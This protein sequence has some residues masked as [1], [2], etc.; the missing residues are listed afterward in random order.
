[1]SYKQFSSF[2]PYQGTVDA[3]PAPTKPPNAFDQI[4][5]FLCRKGR[6][7][8][9]PGIQA[10]GNPLDG[11]ILRN[12]LTFEDAVGDFHSLAL[13]T[14]TPYFVTSGPTYNPLTLPGGIESLAGTA[15]PFGMSAINNRIYFSNGSTKVLY[16]DGETS[17]KVAG[18]VQGAAYFMGVLGNHALLAKT[19]EPAPGTAGSIRFSNRIRWSANGDPDTWTGFGTGFSD[20]LD[21]FGAFT[22]YY[23]M[24]R[25]GYIYRKRGIS[26]AYITGEG[27]APFAIEPYSSGLDGV[28][29]DLDY[30]LAGYGNMNVF[31][32][33]NDIYS[34]NGQE[35]QPI[36]GKA[37]KAIFA[38]LSV[39]SGDV[40]RGFIIPRVDKSYDLL[41]YWLCIPGINVVWVY[42]F[43]DDSWQQALSTTGRINYIG[44][45]AV[46]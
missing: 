4:V 39:A 35:M 27:D 21:E 17:V 14:K 7:I 30:S 5:N 26:I 20:I 8:S 9:R 12:A 46:S 34:F 25:N 24:G 32:A 6:L 37:K 22:G 36:G 18:D 42:L 31:V 13:T 16:A 11:A 41:S 44:E 45:L 3:M 38:D 19:I 40:V 29:N 2:G 28:G 43:D 33:R 1:M 23:T 10:F 15:L